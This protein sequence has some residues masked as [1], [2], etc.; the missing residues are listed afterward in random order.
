MSRESAQVAVVTGA[1]RGV[2]QGIA[3]ALL[4]AAQAEQGDKSRQCFCQ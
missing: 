1:S 2:D 3:Q 4:H